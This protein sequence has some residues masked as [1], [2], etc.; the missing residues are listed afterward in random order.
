VNTHKETSDSEDGWEVHR[1]AQ[2]RR[3]RALSLSDK[4]KAVQGMAE[5]AR[6]FESMRQQ[7]AFRSGAHLSE[8]ADETVNH[9]V[10]DSPG[11][12]IG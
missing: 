1:I 2:L 7:G 5:V 11:D 9:E 10:K 3:F 8:L 12:P 4:M 6:R